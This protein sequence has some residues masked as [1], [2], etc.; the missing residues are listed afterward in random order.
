MYIASQETQITHE[1]LS[2]LIKRAHYIFTTWQLCYFA[3]GKNGMNKKH[4]RTCNNYKQIKI[5]TFSC[6]EYKSPIY[7]AKVSPSLMTI[8]IA[9]EYIAVY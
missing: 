2:Y 8:H 9:L 6:I 1:T 4:D 7:R 3:I 5:L